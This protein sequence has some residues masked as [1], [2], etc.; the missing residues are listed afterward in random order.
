MKLVGRNSVLK[1]AL[2]AASAI[3]LA[4]CATTEGTGSATVPAQEAAALP[5]AA[6]DPVA[7][8]VTGASRGATGVVR[9]A[10]GKEAKVHVG[11]EYVSAAGDRCKRVILTDTTLRKTQVS[12]VC[13]TDK[14]WNT[15]VGL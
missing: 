15:V 12:A 10:S 4:G 6:G 9:M 13:L 3:A 2:F 1:I 8:Y 7:A 14:G 5:A 11:V